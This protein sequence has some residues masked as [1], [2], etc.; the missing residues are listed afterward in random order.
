MF[1][2]LH[3][4]FVW[5]RSD[6]QI[7]L[8][9]QTTALVLEVVGVEFLSGDEQP[10]L[11]VGS[12]SRETGGCDLLVLFCESPSAVEV[13]NAVAEVV[14]RTEFESPNLGGWVNDGWLVDQFEV[15]GDE[16]GRPGQEVLGVVLVFED[17]HVVEVDSAFS[18]DVRHVSEETP[19]AGG[20]CLFVAV[21]NSHVRVWDSGT[22]D[23]LNLEASIALFALVNVRVEADTERNVLS[24]ASAESEEEPSGADLAQNAISL[25]AI[26]RS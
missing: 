14:S 5:C 8:H 7:V 13:Q 2:V 25:T 20:T 22:S 19:S 23:A 12:R 18:T 10:Q 24:D 17:Q 15:E 21:L 16:V 6:R 1:S 4:D 26:L 9:V 11:V 3:L